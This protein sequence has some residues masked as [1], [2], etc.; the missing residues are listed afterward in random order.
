MIEARSCP[1]V[2]DRISHHFRRRR[3]AH[4]GCVTSRCQVCSNAAIAR[5]ARTLAVATT[6][7]AMKKR[8]PGPAPPADTE[9]ATMPARAAFERR[10]DHGSRGAECHGCN[11][12]DDQHAAGIVSDNQD[13]SAPCQSRNRDLHGRSAFLAQVA[14]WMSS[15]C[16]C[17]T[18]PYFG[19]PGARTRKPKDV[20]GHPTAVGWQPILLPNEPAHGRADD[21]Y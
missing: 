6:A 2:C 8:M 18:P 4:I 7:N 20:A 13:G 17:F 3:A 14:G 10:K 5:R 11:Q 15:G 9:L 1:A 16:L 12:S 21:T 19:R